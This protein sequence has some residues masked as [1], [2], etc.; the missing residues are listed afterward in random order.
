M[1]IS[2][3]CA[4]ADAPRHGAAATGSPVELSATLCGSSTPTAVSEGR[5]AAYAPRFVSISALL[6]H[7][8][9]VA[10]LDDR[11]GIRL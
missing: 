6:A 2:A 8:R 3:L 5:R 11:L 9:S 10:R 1:N 4:C 7:S